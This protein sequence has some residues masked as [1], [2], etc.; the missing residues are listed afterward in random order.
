MQNI[1]G[2]IRIFAILMAASCLFY[3][4]FSFVT[5][6]WEKK[7]HLYAVNYSQNP[8]IS[9]WA[10]ARANGDSIKLREIIDSVITAREHFFLD[11]S[12]AGK[13]IY[14]GLYTYES[15]KDKELNLGLDLKGGM[16]V[17]IEVSTPDIIRALANYSNSPDFTQAIL[18]AKD[19][20]LKSNE[21]FISLFAKAYRAQN[22]QARLSSLFAA[23]LKQYDITF[24]STDEQVLAAIRKENE[25]AVDRAKLVIETRINKFGVAQAN[26]QHLKGTNRILVELPG[27]KD[28]ERVDHLLKTA[29]NLEFWETYEYSEVAPKLKEANDKLSVLLGYKKD[30]L[31]PDSTKKIAVYKDAKTKKDSLHA[32]S[33]ANKNWITEVKR[34]DST[35]K[36]LDSLTQAANKAAGKNEA[37]PISDH[38]VLSNQQGKGPMLFGVLVKDTS[39]IAGYLRRP[40]IAPMF[41][42]DMRFAWS[43]KPE[44]LT[45]G[46]PFLYLIA[47]KA[48]PEGRASL[49]GDVVTDARKQFDRMNG[50]GSPEISMTMNAEGTHSWARL[51][52]ANVGRS[53]AIVLDNY[54]YTYPTVQGEIPNGTSQIT[55][56]FTNKEADDL[57]NVLN[58]G[59][60]PAPAIIVEKT[61]VGATLG[62]EAIRAGMI[63]FL[64]ALVVVLIYMGFYY[65]KAGWVA[66]IALFVNVFFIMG[67]LSSLGAVLTLPGIAGI[68]L[69]IALSVD[70]N[71]L[72][73]ERVR[74]ELREGKSLNNALADGY[75]HAMS[76]ILD[77]NLTTLILGIILYSFG[78][79]P[80]QGFATTLII[81][82][83]SSLFCAIFITRLI[84]DWMLKKEQK[85]PFSVPATENVL[86]NAKVDFVGRRKFYYMFSS[87]IIITGVIFWFKHNGFTL[88]VDFSGGRSYTVRFTKN[89]DREKVREALKVQFG[90]APEVKTAGGN[91]QLKITTNYMANEVTGAVDTLVRKKLDAGIN[92]G[93][94]GA[95]YEVLSSIKVGPTI[96]NEVIAKSFVVIIVSCILMFLYILMRFR[97]WQYGL[98]AVAALVHD[99]LVVLSCYT[100][101]DGI[102]PFPL[103]VDQHFVAAILTVMGYSMTDTVVVF[104]RI[105]EFLAKE[106]K[107]LGNMEKRSTINYA[108]NSTLTRTINTSMITFFVLSAI[109]WFGGETIRGFSF[110]LL[111]GVIIGTYSSLCI[112]TPIVVDFDR[113]K[114]ADAAK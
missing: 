17:T 103:E 81:G 31:F 27:V 100:I 92:S 16:N 91:D 42:H 23:Q 112:A 101:F 51:T 104:D 102:L 63:S 2:A 110:A 94:G 74:E 58:T 40:E 80:V 53:V 34:V 114:D 57:V 26:V 68:V 41:P 78:T 97:K 28:E 49:M 86:R 107:T 10:K 84:F 69:T 50:S 12:I 87:A 19:A 24:N 15:C 8:K 109:F 90:M 76:S 1:K 85:I 47:L 95:K 32:D 108:L 48:G 33:I 46:Q 21:D 7:A 9:D 22:P 4:S 30:T 60:L 11:D 29:A 77:S 3:L 67:I 45:T 59:K 44:Y 111:I 113:R 39:V 54:V 73:F 20:Q 36:A 96:A 61:V 106:G 75:K 38:I 105:R 99:V 52:K 98:G 79:G 25:A 6:N 18:K 35:K 83:I 65:N 89:V 66:D 71:V 13:K 70:A 5:R 37:T 55:G 93:D 82:I 14:L 64:V 43:V 62:E 72:I 56:N 88:G